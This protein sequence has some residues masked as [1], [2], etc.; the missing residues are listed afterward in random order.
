[1]ANLIKISQEDFGIVLV[2]AVRYCFGR[3]TYMPSLIM[4]IVKNY[5]SK[6]DD[7]TVACLERDVREAL[8]DDAS[9][10]LKIGDPNIDLP[11]W[12]QFYETLDSE[13][14]RRNIG[15]W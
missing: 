11:I 5:M 1:M 13:V 4:G 7:R 2:D 8:K 9:G 12:K 14:T 15:R 10:L 6:L 3:Q